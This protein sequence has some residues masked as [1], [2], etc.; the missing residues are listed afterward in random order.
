M[1]RCRLLFCAFAVVLGLSGV[2]Y[3]PPAAAQ[4]FKQQGLPIP[5]FFFSGA[6][7]RAREACADNLP[8]CRASVRARMN[9]EMEI[10]L[11]IPY[12]VLAVGLITALVWLRGQEKKK[13]KARALARAHHDPGAFRKLDKEK[14]EKRDTD[15]DEDEDQL[16]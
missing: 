6:E 1:K 4:V 12:I 5:S 8:N 9:Q 13:A 11:T 14:K 2:G 7:R 3:T 10:S 16:S 15:D